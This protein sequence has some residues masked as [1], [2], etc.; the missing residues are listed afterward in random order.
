MNKNL[1]CFYIDLWNIG[2]TIIVFFRIN[3]YNYC[4]RF[5]FRNNQLT[6]IF[7]EDLLCT[8]CRSAFV[9]PGEIC[10]KVGRSHFHSIIVP[11]V[12]RNSSRRELTNAIFPQPEH[13]FIMTTFTLL[14]S[15]FDFRRELLYAS[16]KQRCCSSRPKSFVH[17]F[18]RSIC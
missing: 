2:L 14:S 7:S 5:N 15:S 16:N 1:R 4:L 13:P 6:I 10:T 12:R 8:Q 11:F 18:I 17:A 9:N 3:M